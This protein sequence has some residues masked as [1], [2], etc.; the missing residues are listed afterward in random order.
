MI[1]LVAVLSAGSVCLGSS[2]AAAV[3]PQSNVP[4]VVNPWAALSA[5]SSTASAA[6]LCGSAAAAAAQD[7]S[8]VQDTRDRRCV[9]PIMDDPGAAG[10]PSAPVAAQAP[11]PPIAAAGGFA[12]SPLLL[13]LGA[14]A[15]GA[16]AYLL[17]EGGNHSGHAVSPA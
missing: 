8:A 2:A 7:E 3:V 1:R 13:A 11:V 17:L 15:T 6:A 14:L 10:L 5:L 9:L 12:F 4:P 16:L